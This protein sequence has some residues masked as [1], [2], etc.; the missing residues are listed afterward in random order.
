MIDENLQAIESLPEQLIRARQLASGIAANDVR[1]VYICGIGGSALPVELLYSLGDEIRAPVFAVR[2]YKLPAIAG[3]EDLAIIIS[4]S[5]N[6]EETLSC[7][8]QAKERGLQQI[9]IASGGRLKEMASKDGYPFIEVPS[10][11][12][13]R[14]AIGY[15]GGIVLTILQNSGLASQELDLLAAAEFLRGQDQKEQARLIANQIGNRLP[16]IYSSRRLR[17]AAYK[18]KI[19]IN[20][21][22]KREAFCNELPEFN[23]NEMQGFG[24]GGRWS[25]FCIFLADAIEHPRVTSRIR[26]TKDLIAKRIG[27]ANTGDLTI[28]GPSHIARLFSAIQLGDLVSY[29][30]AKQDGTEVGPVPMVDELKGALGTF[31]PGK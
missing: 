14:A 3:P 7:Y 20:E 27:E 4:Y 2:E 16:H 22:A 29:F 25:P 28:R 1:H 19:A 26:I 24:S 6:T 5:G 13:P 15:L 31:S 17:G 30:L 11:F 9:V 18:W 12:Q 10:G 23:H 21:N 8:D